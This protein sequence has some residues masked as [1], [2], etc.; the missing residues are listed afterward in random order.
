MKP[1]I[2]FMLASFCPAIVSFAR[3]A[4][5][6]GAN[7][8]TAPRVTRPQKV[9]APFSERILWLAAFLVLLIGSVIS[10]GNAAHPLAAG[11]ASEYYAHI[12]AFHRHRWPDL[13]PDTARAVT[14]MAAQHGYSN[15]HADFGYFPSPRDNRL[16]GY[17][18]WGYGLA[19]W[20]LR[21]LLGAIGG[22]P[23]AAPG[24]FNFALFLLTFGVAF[25]L[26]RAGRTVLPLAL[27]TLCAGSPLLWYLRWPTPEVWTW[28]GVF[29]A[30]C[31]LGRKRFALAAFCAALAAWQNPPVLFLAW[32]CVALAALHARRASLPFA[33]VVLPA[34]AAA[35]LCFVPNAFYLYYFG[36]SS[37]IFATV[38]KFD[39]NNISFAR[40]GDILFDLN[41]GMLPYVPFIMLAAAWSLVRALR[42]KDGLALGGFAVLL[43]MI[44]ACCLN[45]H[46]NVGEAGMRRYSA[47]M[48][49]LWAWLAL[50]PL[51]APQ[52]SRLVLVALLWQL[53][54]VSTHDGATFFRGH[55]PWARWVLSNAPALYRP[56]PIVFTE[57][58]PQH[59]A[60]PENAAPVAFVREDGSVSKLLIAK[61]ALPALKR[62]IQVDARWLAQQPALPT[63]GV[64][65]WH[66]PR[67]AVVAR[68]LTRQ[69][70]RDWSKQH[71]NWMNTW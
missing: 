42:R 67:G 68:P 21:A 61:R 14:R 60:S 35:L 32:W 34:V 41:Q 58:S 23:F 44:A 43:L 51:P 1:H 37:L 8:Q 18:F 38:Y 17:H 3:N 64:V 50:R 62:D 27:W 48:L 46:W 39:L 15:P 24:L 63:R 70:Y 13:R 71:D 7:S 47:W 36:H 66:P 29:L 16:Y 56:D 52:I 2:L 59:G 20:P 22:D 11:D 69:R 25:S 40:F 9:A 53:A 28:S 33:R 57:R 4:P 12:E 30:L 55:T 31:A 45:G 5:H 19:V 6:A 10:L 54:I 65:F 26:A 49:P